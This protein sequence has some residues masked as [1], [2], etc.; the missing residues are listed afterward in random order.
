M[1]NT[2]IN[3]PFFQTLVYSSLIFFNIMMFVSIFAVFIIINAVTKTQ[4]KVDETLEKIQ[5]SA[6]NIAEA[7]FSLGSFVSQ[8]TFLQPKKSLFSWIINTIKNF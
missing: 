5:N 1:I 7:G 4:E 3:N 8:L 6:I 2:M